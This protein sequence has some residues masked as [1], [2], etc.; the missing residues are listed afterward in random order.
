MNWIW[1]ASKYK[2][3]DTNPI[4]MLLTYVHLPRPYF[5]MF[6]C[7]F[8]QLKNQRAHYS[9]FCNLSLLTFC[10]EPYK[11]RVHFEWSDL[12]ANLKEVVLFNL[13]INISQTNYSLV[14][15]YFILAEGM[16]LIIIII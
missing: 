7:R 11:I 14:K 1:D 3:K 16:R 10:K 4:S 5:T 8:P 9:I 15:N 6:L 13:L 2:T 12:S